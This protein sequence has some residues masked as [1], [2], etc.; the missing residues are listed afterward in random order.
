MSETNRRSL[1]AGIVALVLSLGSLVGTAL[2]FSDWRT[3]PPNE[4]PPELVLGSVLIVSAF[5]FGIYAIRSLHSRI[6]SSVALELGSISLGVIF[7]L[8]GGYYLFQGLILGRAIGDVLLGSALFGTSIVFYL[9]GF[10]AF[11]FVGASLELA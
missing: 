1:G 7:A 6:L 4:F 8:V 11:W 9:L 2:L 3:R 5:L 10:A